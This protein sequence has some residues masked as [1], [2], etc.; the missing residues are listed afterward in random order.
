MS[1]DDEPKPEPK[2]RMSLRS[3]GLF[4]YA[5]FPDGKP[6]QEVLATMRLAYWH[7]WPKEAEWRG[8]P[9]P[10]NLWRLLRSLTVDEHGNPW[11]PD[12]DGECSRCRSPHGRLRIVCDDCYNK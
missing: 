12:Q 7:Y 6:T 3:D 11:P 9:M 1:V 8:A 10:V 5:R 4:Y 2:P